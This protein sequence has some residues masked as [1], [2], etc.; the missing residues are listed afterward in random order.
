[1]DPS[2]V[3]NKYRLSVDEVRRHIEIAK[4]SKAQKLE[5]HDITE[6]DLARP[7]RVTRLGVGPLLTAQG[8]FQHFDFEV[9]DKWVKYSVI[10]RADLDDRL[11]P[12]FDSRSPI[13]FRIDSGC[14][15]GQLFGDVTCECRDQLDLVLKRIAAHGQGFV[16][17]IPRQDGRGM[18]LP[19]KLAT[20]YLQTVL[21]V[22]T[23]EAGALL[24]PDA[25]RDVRTYSGA[26]A[27]MRFLR[28]SSE[29]TLH[30]ASN[31]PKKLE[32]FGPNGYVNVSPVSLK[33]E[34]TE[35][36]HRH[37]VAKQ[38]ELGHRG[39]VDDEDAQE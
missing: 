31:N 9:S 10:V 12:V 25:S 18:G 26:L 37:L 35:H 4:R 30:L 29:A 27:I 17:N 11:R 33:V 7:I 16:I 23:V 6:G 36:T 1:M 8:A 28:I 21:R 3:A 20:L 5:T 14:E 34:P 13:L 2:D 19:F 39:L 24:E 15:T 32:I 38:R 22:D